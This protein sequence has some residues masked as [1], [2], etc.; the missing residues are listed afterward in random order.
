M[1][2]PIDGTSD[3]ILGDTGFVVM[4]G[5]AIGGRPAVGAVGHPLSRKVYAGAVGAGAWVETADGAAHRCTRRPSPRPPASGWSRPR[6]TA[7]R[8]IDAI[9]K[10]LMI[11]RRD[12]RRQR[13]PQDRAG[14]R[15]GARSLPLH[16]RADEDL[17]HL[18]ARSDPARGGRQDHRRR[19]QPADLRRARSSTTAEASSP[20]TARCTTS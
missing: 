3:F 19:R 10:A 7:R 8:R 6:P 5:L 4:I 1:V 18:R 11:Y 20:R 13:R 16:R 9:K 17:G 12:Q 14:D 15:G 2:D